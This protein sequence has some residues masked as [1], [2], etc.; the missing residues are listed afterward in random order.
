MEYH[1]I[2]KL[3]PEVSDEEFRELGSDIGLKGL[4]DP[5]WTHD[6]QIIDG[7]HR[8]RACIAVGKPPAFREWAGEGGSLIG[9]VISQNLSR[10][11]LTTDQRAALGARL[12]AEL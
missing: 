4:I 11:H 2:C 1:D 9:F 10:R 3:F 6:G 8:Y 12:K 7:R 5:I